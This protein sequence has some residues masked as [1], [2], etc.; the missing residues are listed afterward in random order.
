MRSTSKSCL[1]IRFCIVKHPRG[2]TPIYG[3]H[4]IFRKL[5]NEFLYIS[6]VKM[7]NDGYELYY[8]I[9]PNLANLHLWKYNSYE[10][11]F[12]NHNSFMEI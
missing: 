7:D 5:E 4:Q 6:K 8:V 10:S 9:F 1:F 12:E 11:P 2:G 3:N